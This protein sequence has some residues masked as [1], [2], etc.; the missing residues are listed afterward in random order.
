MTDR[1][2][3]SAGQQVII[4]ADHTKLGRTAPAF[5]APLSTIDVLVTDTQADRGICQSMQ[6]LGIL[7][8]QA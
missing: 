7:V 8:I 2:I 4:V 5:V 1:A 6:E 3:L